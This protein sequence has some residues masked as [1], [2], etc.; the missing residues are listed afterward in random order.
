MTSNNK[1][2]DDEQQTK[3]A[4]IS[5]NPFGDNFDIEVKRKALEMSDEEERANSAWFQ[6]K[7]DETRRAEILFLDG[8]PCPEYI[9]KKFKNQIQQQVINGNLV[10]KMCYKYTVLDRTNGN[11][12][13]KPQA[14]EVGK[15]SNTLIKE[16]LRAGHRILDITRT[17]TGTD[18]LYTPT[19][20][21]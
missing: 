4:S 12:D 6:I 5:G 16:Q 19:P 20:V 10:T 18:T 1:R 15:N 11:K 13:P 2:I 7:Q 21:Q 9:P 17:G 8:V 3:D 14:F